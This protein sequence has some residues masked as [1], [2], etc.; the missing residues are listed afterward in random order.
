MA[1]TFHDRDGRAVFQHYRVRTNDGRGKRYGY[2]YPARFQNGAVV[3]WIWRK[4]PVADSLIYRLPVVLANSRD[5]LWLCEGERDA[6]EFIVR[7]LLAS[8]HHGGAGKFTDAQ[9]ESLAGHRGEIVLVA[10]RDEAG[11]YDVVR[12]FDRL[13]S[14]GVPAA[15]LR[16]VHGRPAH[17]GADARDHFNAG[18]AVSDFQQADIAKLR[19]VAAD[20]TSTVFS[21]A[22]YLTPEEL[23]DLKH[24]RPVTIRKP[25]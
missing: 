4:P 17:K 5:T 10:D 20:A 3:E 15:Q 2:R 22:G 14:V 13:R 19:D 21:E 7:G 1:W 9:A 25:G 23:A 11:A 6:S 12:R 8:S 16:V 18:Y 24:W